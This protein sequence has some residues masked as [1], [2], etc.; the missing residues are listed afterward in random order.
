MDDLSYA[1]PADPTVAQ[2]LDDEVVGP[3]RVAGAPQAV[4][5][6]DNA[7]A[8]SGLNSTA[9]MPVSVLES[10]MWKRAPSRSWSRTC[11]TCRSQSSLALTP[12]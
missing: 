7:S 6:L 9:R 2:V 3:S 10:R 1:L 4:E 11:R 5:M 8:K 12:L